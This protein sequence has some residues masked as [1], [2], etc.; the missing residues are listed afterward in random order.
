MLLGEALIEAMDMLE[1]SYSTTSPAAALEQAMARAGRFTD[2]EQLRQL[3]ACLAVE[4][5]WMVPASPSLGRPRTAEEIFR[6]QTQL[7]VWVWDRRRDAM[8][9]LRRARELLRGQS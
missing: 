2:V 3:A 8:Q 5:V 9:R 7:R 6:R 4:A 1:A